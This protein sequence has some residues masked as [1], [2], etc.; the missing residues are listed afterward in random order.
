MMLARALAILVLLGV[1]NACAAPAPRTAGEGAADRASQASSAGAELKTLTLA[2]RYEKNDLLTKT[3]SQA[4][5]EYR[6]I[7]NAGLAIV[8]G[9][10]VPEPQLATD[11]PRLNTESWRVTPDGKMETTWHLKPGLTWHDGQPLTADDF[12]FA[13]QVYTAP[14]LGIFSPA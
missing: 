14:G 13:Y 2:F 5:Q 7:F 4:G 6:P 11:T 9:G 1:L 10:A 3:L 12:V 8:G